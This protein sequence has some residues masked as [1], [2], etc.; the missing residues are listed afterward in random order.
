MLLDTYYVVCGNQAIF[1]DVI[2]SENE[3][4]LKVSFSLNNRR[5]KFNVLWKSYV[6]TRLF[7][8]HQII[9]PIKKEL[10]LISELFREIFCQTP[11]GDIELMCL[12]V[13]LCIFTKPPKA[14]KDLLN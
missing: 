1:V 3:F 11:L 12:H 10:T 6:C 4:L 2:E 8:S 14:G 5:Y 13:V 9:E 7:L